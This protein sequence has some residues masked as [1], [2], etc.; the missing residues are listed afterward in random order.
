MK[1]YAILCFCLLLSGLSCKKEEIVVP[2]AT[3][4]SQVPPGAPELH[5][6]VFPSADT[7]FISCSGGQVLR[8]VNGGNSWTVIQVGAP[9]IDF[10][11]LSFVNSQVGY[12]SGEGFGTRVLYKTTDGG[13]TWNMTGSSYEYVEI[14]FITVNTGYMLHYSFLYKTTNGGLSWTMVNTL[15]SI[16]YPEDLVFLSVD[17]GF[18]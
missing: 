5:D 18:M 15:S 9:E 10:E 14:E 3:V 6:I 1:H 12:V 2:V 4:S 17:T 7:G 11:Y 16:D 8:T 13:L